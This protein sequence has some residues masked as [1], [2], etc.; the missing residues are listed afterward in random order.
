MTS[1]RLL[2]FFKH[3]HSVRADVVSLK[4]PEYRDDLLL[5]QVRLLLDKVEDLRDVA[6]AVVF[7]LEHLDRVDL[8]QKER[9]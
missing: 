5:L 7:L 9:L 6:D 1:F 4:I 8:D 2:H 3:G